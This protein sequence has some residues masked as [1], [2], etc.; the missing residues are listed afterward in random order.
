MTVAIEG[1]PEAESKE[2]LAFLFAH[3]EK[4][5]F[6]YEHVWRVSDLLLWDNRCALHARSDFSSDERR[7]MR[8]VTVLGERPA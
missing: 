1:L 4:S 8:R 7:L 5:K 6:I 3:Q 2:L